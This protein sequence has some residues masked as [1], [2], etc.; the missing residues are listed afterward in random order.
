MQATSNSELEDKIRFYKRLSQLRNGI[1]TLDFANAA[2]NQQLIQNTKQ[3]MSNLSE[4]YRS[5]E[6]ERNEEAG[7]FRRT[8]GE[9]LPDRLA[10][11]SFVPLA[12]KH[13][14]GASSNN[15]LS[16]EQPRQRQL[17]FEGPDEEGPDEEEIDEEELQ[18]ALEELDEEE[19]A[20]R[21]IEMEEI[22]T[23]VE[24][25]YMIVFKNL[26][27]KINKL[28]EKIQVNETSDIATLLEGMID[29]IKE[30]SKQL[31]EVARNQGKDGPSFSATKFSNVL[32]IIHTLLELIDIDINNEKKPNKSFTIK[33]YNKIKGLKVSNKKFPEFH[34]LLNSLNGLLTVLYPNTNITGQ[35]SI[36]SHGAR[37]KQE[38][39]QADK[40]SRHFAK[41]KEKDEQSETE[42][43]KP[44]DPTSGQGIRKTKAKAKPP[45][46]YQKTMRVLIGSRLSGNK[47]K[48]L[49]NRIMTK[50]EQ[51]LKKGYIT[52]TE[53]TKIIE[54]I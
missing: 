32:E 11:P 47:S 17:D 33:K 48:I 23:P 5:V 6:D 21:V 39:K 38:Q 45:T 13:S 41:G 14:A 7:R 8:Y 34:G 42:E 40:V 19:E 51:G 10:L 52:K 35:Q 24:E 2:N 50:I 49:Y 16:F 4:A 44:K 28:N 26:S 22:K 36:E 30:V 20:G 12:L 18:R 53:A 3:Y 9:D 25:Q 29:D 54:K 27:K 43:E 37:A 46:N 31:I 15:Q 1:R